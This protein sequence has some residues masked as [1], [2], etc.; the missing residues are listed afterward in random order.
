[1]CV[2]LF[3]YPVCPPVS[4]YLPSVSDLVVLIHVFQVVFLTDEQVQVLLPISV[5]CLHMSLTKNKLFAG[6]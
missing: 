6:I 1:M 4:V 3:E 5:H 2:C